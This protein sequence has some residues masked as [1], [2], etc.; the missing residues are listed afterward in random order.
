MGA[1][2]CRLPRTQRDASRAFSQVRGSPADSPRPGRGYRHAQ[3][4][5]V[6]QRASSQG[7]RNL[8]EPFRLCNH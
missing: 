5:V 1:N 4:Q 3:A 7:V 8:N 6:W 2:V